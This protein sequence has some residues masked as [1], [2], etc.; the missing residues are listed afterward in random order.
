MTP[1]ASVLVAADEV[2]A[3]EFIDHDG[4][5]PANSREALKKALPGL[6]K[7]LPD[8]RFTIEQL[9]GEGDLV[10]I[11]LRGEATH[12][13]VVMGISPTG[14]KITWTANEIYRME[15][16]PLAESWGQARSTRRWRRSVW[17]SKPRRAEPDR[18]NSVT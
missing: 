10:C 12:T 2:I 7:A 3:P 18:L 1:A 17:D 5:D 9:F 14:K 11:R 15:S 13:G 8:L 6:L 4:P 16:G